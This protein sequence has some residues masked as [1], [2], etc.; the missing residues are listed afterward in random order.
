LYHLKVQIKGSLEQ[1]SLARNQAK[2][3]SGAKELKQL[4]KIDAK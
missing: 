2:N 3:C 4:E 1:F